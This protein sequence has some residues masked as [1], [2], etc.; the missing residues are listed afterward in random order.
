MRKFI[1][2]AV[3]VELAGDPPEPVLVRDGETAWPIVQVERAWFDTGHGGTPHHARSWRTRR[4]R[5]NFT[6]VAESGERLNVYL[7]Y[8]RDD[9]PVWQLVTLDSE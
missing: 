5:K 2:R 1:G 9:R 3:E 4:H 8:A 6:L 7:D